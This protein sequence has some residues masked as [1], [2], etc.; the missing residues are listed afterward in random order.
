MNV[1]PWIA[2]SLL[3]AAATQPASRADEAVPVGGYLYANE[4]V[5]SDFAGSLT[6]HFS[7]PGTRLV[8][9]YGQKQRRELHA[10]QTASESDRALRK[11]IRARLLDQGKTAVFSNLPPD[12]YDVVVV[13]TGTM[14]LYEG[15]E[16]LSGSVKQL[17]E[18]EVA[19]QLT[20]VQHSL[21]DDPDR[22]AGGWESFFDQKEFLRFETD[23]QDGAFLV[24]QTRQ[25]TAYAESGQV[26]AGCI[27]SIDICWVRKARTAEAG[28]QVISRRQLYRAELESRAFFT[29]HFLPQLRRIRV[30]VRDIVI[31]PIEL[32]PPTGQVR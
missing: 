9:A 16:M 10:G 27:H 20:E 21:T 2:L 19:A 32:P 6:I 11:P 5:L 4:A 17:P 30:G 8:L 13:D 29:H 12:F 22:L 18:Q 23:G 15:L 24:Q 31:G 26:I 3:V 7:T 25:G 1:K 14:S 28:W